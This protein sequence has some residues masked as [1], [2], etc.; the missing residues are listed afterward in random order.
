MAL[1]SSDRLIDVARISAIIACVGLLYSP[2]VG[3]IGLIV[4]YTA[5]LAS[6]QAVVRF[7][8]AVARPMVYWGGAFL[9]IVLLG[10]M[11]ASVPWQDRWLDLYKWR[12]IVWF[13]VVL[14]IFD[15]EQWKDRFLTAFLMAT[16][17]GLIGSFI[18]AAGWVNFRRAPEHLLR[19]SGTQGMAFASAALVCTWMIKDHPLSGQRLRVM[20]AALGLLYAANLVFI[21][22]ARSGYAVLGVGFLVLLCW[23]AS[24]A[25]RAMILVG[26]IAFGAV[27]VSVSPRMQEKVSAAVTQWNE[28]AEAKTLTSFG[29][30]RIFYTNSVEI[31][32]EHWLLGVGTGG[33][34]QAYGEH[35]SKKYPSSDWRALPATDPHSQY[36]SVAIQQGIAGVVLF[37]T[38][39]VSIVREREAQRNYHRLAVAILMGWCVTSL[40]SSHFRTFAE[41]HMLAT[42][43]GV[44]LAAGVN[45]AEP[46]PVTVNATDA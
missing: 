7:K 6:G 27:A 2:S 23:Q 40:F 22:D 13:V 31:L 12:T 24:W 38:W 19:I 16:G 1:I 43:L 44:F 39:I 33:F 41:G 8:S 26:L 29:S 30:R 9:G 35:V 3:T 15:K 17:I 4:T 10:M 20:C 36:L 46:E 14:A 18:A 32:R 45:G 37:I 5:F 11:Y 28:E 25:Y 42:F 34:V 21:T